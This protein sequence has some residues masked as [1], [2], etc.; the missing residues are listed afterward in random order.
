MNAHT[1]L[2]GTMSLRIS[3]SMAYGVTLIY[4]MMMM[5]NHATE[6]HQSC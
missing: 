4:S 6:T 2:E 1:I 3:G 5:M